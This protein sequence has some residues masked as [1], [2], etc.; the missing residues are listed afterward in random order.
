MPSSFVDYDGDGDLSEGVYYEIQ[1]LQE[2]LYA[3]MQTYAADTLGTGLVYDASSY[4]YFFD[5][6]GER[7]GVWSPRLVRAAYNYQ[8][9]LKDTGAH[10]HGGKYIIQLL[11]DSIADL[12]PELVA[13]LSRIDHGHFAG[14]EEAFRHWDEDGAISSRCSRCHSAEGLPLF[15]QEGVTI[16]QPVSNGFQ[17]ATCHSNVGEFTLYNVTEVTFPSGATIDLGEEGNPAGLCMTCHQGRS[18]GLDVDSATAGMPNNSLGEGLRFINIHY[19]AAG[20]TRYGG[21]V[22]GAYQYEGKEYVGFFEHVPAAQMCQDCHNA[23]Q[24]VIQVDKCAN[25]HEGVETQEDVHT[26]RVSDVDYDGDGDVEEGLSG[27]VATMNELLYAAMQAYSE[28]NADTATIVYDSHRYPYFFD[29]A[30][31][32]YT[33]WTPALLKAAYNYQYAAKDPGGFAHNGKYV[34]QVLY[35]SIQDLGGDVSG[36]TR[37]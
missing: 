36:L 3:A 20:A 22:N 24:L 2:I 13:G 28:A 4:P 6:A 31:E 30:G 18:T 12:N 11:Y 16:T 17:C 37:P 34:L 10:A 21:E 8:V 32:R 33:T 35:D 23:H 29:D 1:G 15:L 14:S 27:E 25:C 19:F 26:I 9:S 7:L 5:D